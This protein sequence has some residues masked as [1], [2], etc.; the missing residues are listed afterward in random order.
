MA[1][2][3]KTELRGS[4]LRRAQNQVDAGF[5][6]LMKS[7]TLCSS[8]ACVSRGK[9]L[10]VSIGVSESAVGVG[11][12]TVVVTVSVIDVDEVMFSRFWRK[13]RRQAE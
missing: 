2:C 6:R 13:C 5:R 3:S 12:F 4:T 7:E 10:W 11:V 8:F 1:G 9:E